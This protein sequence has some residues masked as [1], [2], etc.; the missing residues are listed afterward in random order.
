MNSY[1]GK[2]GG[3]AP[4]PAM[5]VAM[6]ILGQRH[7]RNQSTTPLDL[8][9]LV[10]LSHGWYLGIYKTPLIEEHV[11]AWPYGPVVPIVYERFKSYKGN[12]IDIVPRDNSDQLHPRQRGVIDATLEAYSD[13]DS[14]SLSAITHEPGTPWYQ[15]HDQGFPQTIPNRIIQQH[16]AELY[17]KRHVHGK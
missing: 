1:S 14:W 8:I 16:Y 13:Y 10:Y 3:T 17:E 15:V 5:V 6:Y 12:P 11:K 2:R 9:K 4:V 7:K